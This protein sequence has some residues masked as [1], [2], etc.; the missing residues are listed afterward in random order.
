MKE[1]P[2]L[3]HTDSYKATHFMQYPDAEEMSCYMECR[4]PLAE[5]GNGKIMFYGWRYLFEQIVER[6]VTMEDIIEADT[7]YEHHGVGGSKFCWPRDLWLSVVQELDGRIPLEIKVLREG[8]VIYKNIPFLQITARGKYARLVTWFETRFSNI[9]A[10][11]VVASKS[12]TVR[13]FLEERFKTSVDE[14]MYFLL[15]SRFHDFGY[16]GCSS[17]ETAMSSGASFLL[18]F[19][20][21]DNQP[22]GWLAT[23]YNN[24]VP[25]GESVIASEHSSMTSW[26]SELEAV[27]HLI[28]I[29]PTGAILSVVADSYDYDNFL[30]NILP[31]AAPLA[32]AKGLLFVIRP[33]SGD[34][35][36]QVEKA[37]FAAEKCFG[38]TK[39]GKGFK[40]LNGAAILQ[41]DG[42]NLDLLFKVASNVEYLGFSAQNVAY[43]MGS[44]LLQE[45]RRDS[46]RLAT[47]LCNIVTKDGVERP[48]MKSPKSDTSKQSLPG[49]FRVCENGHGLSVYPEEVISWEDKKIETN[50]LEICWDSGSINYEFEPF[51]VIRERAKNQWTTRPPFCDVISPQLKDKI[52]EI[53]RSRA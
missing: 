3:I 13:S 36:L 7:W 41:G 45:C 37:L 38:A 49:K 43:G 29:T 16:R 30:D 46:V 26:P 39:N 8:T 48:V 2:F 5:V 12:M 23:K 31:I 24:G 4:G 11:I 10:N 52:A 35:V 34:P 21:T 9:F 51:S 42:L 6:K 33:D 27:Q 32:K 28:S 20:G 40:V 44:G 50:L 17:H 15:D 19:N 14:S 47:K 18:G 22:A 25:I 53:L 1:C